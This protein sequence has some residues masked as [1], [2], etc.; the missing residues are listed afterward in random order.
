MGGVY[1]EIGADPRKF[2]SAM[3]KTN[4]ALAAMGKSLSSAGG[5]MMGMGAA[6]LAPFAA[7]VRSGAAYE[8][9]LLNIRASTGA[10]AAEMEKLRS[11]SMTMS[12]AMGKGPTE[13]AGSFLELLKAGMSVEQVLGGAGKAAIEFATVGQMDVATAA[14]TM[15]DAM[16]VFGVSGD[17]AANTLSAAADSSSVSIAQM[18]EAFANVGAVGASANQSI[19]DMS[20][21]IAILGNNMVKGGDAGTA[22]KTMMLRLTTGADS[23]AEGL[24]EIGLS[25]NDFRDAAGKFMPL[26]KAMDILRNKVDSLGE[27]DRPKALYKIFGSYG[28]KAA[29]ILLKEGA[30]GFDKM[31]TAMDGAAPV[32]EKY[33]TIL[34][35]LSGAGSQAMAA[36]ERFAITVGNAVAPAVMD[37]SKSIVGALNWLTAFAKY[38]PSVVN[39]IAQTA[40]AA[41]ATGGAFI[42]LGS[43][44]RVVGFA[45]GGLIGF[46]KA[47]AAP[48]IMASNAATFLG[49]NFTLAATQL[50]RLGVQGSTALATIGTSAT[51]TGALTLASFTKS[52]GGLAVYT[53]TS[54]A[55]AGA[56]ATAWAA[57]N[58]PLLTLIGTV[59]GAAVV[60]MQLM[61][62]GKELGAS[63]SESIS[64]AATQSVVVF[65]DLYRV[66]TTTFS[67]ISDALAGGDMELAMEA[68]MAGVVAAFTRGSNALLSKLGEMTANIM[69]T[70]DAFQVNVQDPLGMVGEAL[71]MGF[72]PTGPRADLVKRQNARLAKV[73]AD[74]V[75]RAAQST[76]AEGKLKTVA[77]AAAAKRADVESSRSVSERLSS[78]KTMQDV[79]L[80]RQMIG[81]LLDAGNLSAEAE[82]RL[83]DEFQSKFAEMNRLPVA[84][85]QVGGA[86]GVV[87]FSPETAGVFAKIAGA[88]DMKK[89]GAAGKD[90]SD[91]I[92]SDKLTIEEE[93]YLLKAYRDQVQRLGKLED[94]GSGVGT[95]QAEVAGTFSSMALGGMG[96][97]SSLAQQQLDELRGIHKEV[98]D[99]NGAGVAA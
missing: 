93:D 23:A 91:L 4:K 74:D 1:V 66:G 77:E 90:L 61:S 75:A 13:I 62:L 6:A 63:I 80:A 51:T 30:A 70:L 39:A 34:G 82:Q 27:G 60:F 85:A 45:L 29:E 14:V 22:L 67:A 2:F 33:K 76:Q 88:A 9:T 7:S 81:K 72:D 87:G 97:G 25:T 36:M 54:I 19:D 44:L 49:R 20:A 58:L 71:G 48:L 15:S 56:T 31:R 16:N 89:L 12:A 10:T 84:A 28:L 38:N 96:F 3:Q 83:V 47:V 52:L 17:K 78:A 37:L 35:G 94:M 59:G 53:A 98:K 86:G 69:N 64:T 24:K 68:A 26:G 55:S 92:D 21:A 95:S 32:T 11:A 42:G 5:K 8:S 50:V 73:S 65:K 99:A 46:G 43:A 40:V 57:A 41:V 79:D 18:V